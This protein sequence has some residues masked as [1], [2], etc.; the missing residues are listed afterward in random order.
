MEDQQPPN[1][2]LDEQTGQV[3]QRREHLPDPEEHNSLLPDIDP[4]MGVPESHPLQD[5]HILTPSDT[6][7]SISSQDPMLLEES[8]IE[9]QSQLHQHYQ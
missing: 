6:E 2:L 8:A 3:L 9:S 1:L 7:G 5:I 4:R